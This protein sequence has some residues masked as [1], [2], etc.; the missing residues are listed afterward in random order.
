MPDKPSL[1]VAGMD[2]RVAVSAKVTK[3]A[4]GAAAAPT[5]LWPIDKLGHNG[6]DDFCTFANGKGIIGVAEAAGLD[7]SVAGRYRVQVDISARL[8]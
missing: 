8:G 6:F 5:R 4:F 2:D 1:F 3:P 7:A